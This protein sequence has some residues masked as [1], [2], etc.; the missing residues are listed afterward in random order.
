MNG[1][2][3]LDHNSELFIIGAETSCFA[4]TVLV[5]DQEKHKVNILF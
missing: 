5:L 1:N 3:Y 2:D 4:A